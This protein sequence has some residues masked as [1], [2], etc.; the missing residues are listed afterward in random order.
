MDHSFWNIF[1]MEQCNLLID[2]NFQNKKVKNSIKY[3]NDDFKKCFIFMY[4]FHI[5]NVKHYFEKA[6]WVTWRVGYADTIAISN[7]LAGFVE[8]RALYIL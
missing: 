2:C 1:E 5:Y 3:E 8:T 6:I 4:S 7:E